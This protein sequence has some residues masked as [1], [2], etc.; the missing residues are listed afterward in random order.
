MRSTSASL[1]VHDGFV[2]LTL[3]EEH[4]GNIFASDTKQELLQYDFT[5]VKPLDLKAWKSV[6]I[7]RV[8]DLMY[9][10]RVENIEEELIEEN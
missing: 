5:P 10:N 6:I 8:D 4:A 7:P 3:N 2:V 9:E 1:Y